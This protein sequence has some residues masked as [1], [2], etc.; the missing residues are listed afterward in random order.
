MRPTACLIAAAIFSMIGP[1]AGAEINVV[2]ERNREGRATPRFELRVLA[3]PSADDSGAR[4]QLSLIAG[5]RDPTGGE[6]AVLNDGRVP[7]GEDRPGENFFFDAGTPGGR[8]LLDLGSPQSIDR[9]NT[10][11]WHAGGRGPQRYVLWAAAGSAEGFIAGPEAGTDPEKAGWQRVA[12]VDTRP[13]SGEP[14]GQ[15]C[16]SIFGADGTIGPYRYLLFEVAPADAEDRFGNTFFS[17]IDVVAGPPAPA[18]EPASGVAAF[19]TAG[20]AHDFTI[21]TSGSPDLERWAREALAPVVA[22]WYPRI[23]AMLPSEGFE[24]PARFSI[25]ISDATGGVAAAGGTRITCSGNWFRRN[26][27]GEAKG[28]VV[29]ELVHVVQ[30]YGRQGRGGGN[31]GRRSRPPGWLVE[32]IPDYIRW[33]LYEPQSRGAEIRNLDRARYDASYRISGNFLD[34][35][36]RTRDK[37]IVRKLNAALRAG[38]YEESLWKEW[39]GSTVEEL[40]AAWKA[41]LAKAFEGEDGASKATKGEAKGDGADGAAEK[42]AAPR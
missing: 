9:V 28:A 27:E 29:H 21:D 39:T 38:T 31:G 3:P 19:K 11:S 26:L 4:A 16:V 1:A 30:R 22:E 37:E 24:A 42:S 14:G 6:L 32:G 34:W 25:A 18:G 12:S 2:V 35:V 36:T 10:Y 8:I 40:G 5:R 41:S 13:A 17:E 20:G 23:V 15:H 33:F 7:G